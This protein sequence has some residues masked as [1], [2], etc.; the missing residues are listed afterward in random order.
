MSSLTSQEKTSIAMAFITAYF[1]IKIFFQ[2]NKGAKKRK[3]SP[4][5]L[6]YYNKEYDPI[7]KKEN[8]DDDGGGSVR[9]T[10]FTQKD[11][12]SN[13]NANDNE[14]IPWALFVFWGCIVIGEEYCCLI[15]FFTSI[16]Y[17]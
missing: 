5:D 6:K 9:Q 4:E 1:F 16:L 2:N 11:R 3:T 7:N 13:I 14:N 15:T 10:E 17:A 8:E 12:W